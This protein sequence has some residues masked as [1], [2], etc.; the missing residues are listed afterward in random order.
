MDTKRQPTVWT[1]FKCTNSFYSREGGGDWIDNIG[2]DGW[3]V[4]LKSREDL[5]YEKVAEG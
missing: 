4:G 1:E 3:V 2:I 5:Y